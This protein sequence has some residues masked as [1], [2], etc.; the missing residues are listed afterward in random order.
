MLDRHSGMAGNA[1]GALDSGI[2][3]RAKLLKF[4]AH[5]QFKYLSNTEAIASDEGSTV[6]YLEAKLGDL[7]LDGERAYTGFNGRWNKKAD[8]CYAWWATSMLRVSLLAR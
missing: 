6:N 2:A 7:S 8:T 1:K 5:R 4:L 3:D